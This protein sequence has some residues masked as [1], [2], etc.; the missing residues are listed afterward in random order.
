VKGKGEGKGGEEERNQRGGRGGRVELGRWWVDETL[1][2]L[3]G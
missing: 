2:T 3:V 1:K